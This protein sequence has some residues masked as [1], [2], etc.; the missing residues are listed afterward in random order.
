MTRGHTEPS[1]TQCA[2]LRTSR[3]RPETPAAAPHPTQKPSIWGPKPAHI[4]SPH[5]L[6]FWAARLGQVGEALVAEVAFAA[7]EVHLGVLLGG[8][9]LLPGGTVSHPQLG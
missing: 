5:A 3:A 9:A 6:T 4:C 2:Y 7:A 1:V 8:H